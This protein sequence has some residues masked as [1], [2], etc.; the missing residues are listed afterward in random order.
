MRRGN[1]RRQLKRSHEGGGVLISVCAANVYDSPAILQT[2]VRIQWRIGPPH[3]GMRPPWEL[4]L[5]APVELFH[6]R[7]SAR[8]ARR[9]PNKRRL[10]AGA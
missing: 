1:G 8:W 10:P 3:H 7:V 5:I 9:A 4:V 2:F 6:A